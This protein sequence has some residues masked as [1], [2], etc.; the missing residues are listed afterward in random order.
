MP[1]RLSLLVTC[2]WA[3]EERDTGRERR[4]KGGFGGTRE[5]EGKVM[6]RE[7]GGDS[8]QTW[9]VEEEGQKDTHALSVYLSIPIHFP[10]VLV[11]L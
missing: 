7:R 8:G 6:E 9:K 1:Y 4:G 2:V 3:G 11:L 10:V 5:V